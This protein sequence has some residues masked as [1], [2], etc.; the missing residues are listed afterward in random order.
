MSRLT[1]KQEAFA[2][3]Y[4][5]HGSPIEAYRGAGYS[6]AMSANST[7][8][9]AQKL[10]KKPKIADRIAELSARVRKVAE[11]KFDISAERVLRQFEAIAFADA[12]DFVEW[13][14]GAV[15]VKASEDLTPQ[16]RQLITKVKPARGNAGTVE[17]ELADRMKA[18]DALAR[19]V[20]LFELD[21]AQGAQPIQIILNADDAAL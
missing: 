11:E 19:H 9:E 10:L 20:G 14:D 7:A 8:V 17:I 16:Q 12:G 3:H 15:T 1:N 13:K 21:N 5:L 2:Q 6:K 4:A 18:L